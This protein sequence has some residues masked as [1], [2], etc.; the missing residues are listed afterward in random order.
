MDAQMVKIPGA[1]ARWL[2]KDIEA[3]IDEQA[4]EWFA[5]SAMLHTPATADRGKAKQ[6]AA[7]KRLRLLRRA[8]ELLIAGLE[9]RA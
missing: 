1:L 5:G 6:R 9:E 3:Q 2:I 7:V 8:K 4:Q